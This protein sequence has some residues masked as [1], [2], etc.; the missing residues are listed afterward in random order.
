[1]V[2]KKIKTFYSKYFIINIFG[3]AWAC[4]TIT[5]RRAFFAALVLFF[6]LGHGKLLVWIPYR[7]PCNAH[8]M[9]SETTKKL[10]QHVIYRKK[11]YCRATRKN[12]MQ[13]RNT[14]PKQSQTFRHDHVKKEGKITIHS[15]W[16][17][18]GCP[19][20]RALDEIHCSHLNCIKG[21]RGEAAFGG[22]I[23]AKAT[24]LEKKVDEAWRIPSFSQPPPLAPP[25]D[26]IT[27]EVELLL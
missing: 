15:S 16:Q 8:G 1:M 3:K 2:D 25:N 17:I 24:V 6:L 13:K 5:E 27:R 19:P 18:E 14:V 22:E 9:F 21:G 4:R 23:C 10:Q 26:I 11:N 12:K 7:F 20:L